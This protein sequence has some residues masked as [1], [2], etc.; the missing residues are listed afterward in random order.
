MY[1]VERHIKRVDIYSL[2]KCLEQK[3]TPICSLNHLNMF[4]LGL[5]YFAPRAVHSSKF[6]PQ[7]LFV[8]TDDSIL[9]I[10]LSKECVP[11]ILSKFT[12]VESTRTPFSF[13]INANYLVVTIQPDTVQEYDISRIYLK[14]VRMTKKYPLYGHKLPSNYNLDISDYGNCV[15]LST[16]S[17][18]GNYNVFVY[19]SGLP[20]VGSLYNQIDLYAFQHVLMDASGYGID[21]VSIISGKEMRIYRQYET[22]EGRIDNPNEDY[23]F[24]L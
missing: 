18:G 1:T 17:E 7:L 3:C 12:P 20:A 9:A 21:Y 6:H 16:L 23:T 8:K 10:D 13:E 5:K 11:K 15:F 14:E 24:Y 4:Q 2:E 19:R 22:P